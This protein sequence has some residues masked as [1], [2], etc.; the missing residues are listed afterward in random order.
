MGVIPGSMG[1]SSFIVCGKG[2]ETSYQSSSH[3]TGR[4]LGRKAAFRR[5]TTESL[6][7]AMDRRAWDDSMAYQLVDE[8]PDAY[9]PIALVMADQADLVEVVHEL[10]QVVNLKGT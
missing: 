8:H 5:L 2:N 4:R 6:Q 7:S 10:H 3:R 1:A 9:K